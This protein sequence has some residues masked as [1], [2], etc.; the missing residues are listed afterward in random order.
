MAVMN[1]LSTEDLHALR[2]YALALLEHLDERRV[3]RRNGDVRVR[4]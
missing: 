3:T 4:Y 2:R 1:T